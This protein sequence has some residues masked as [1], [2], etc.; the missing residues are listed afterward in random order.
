MSLITQADLETR[1]GAAEVTR[2][3]HGDGSQITSAIAQA[4]SKARSAALNIFTAASWDAMTSATLPGEALYHIVSDAVDILSAGSGRPNEIQAKA[5]EA[6]LWRSWLA[7]GT[8]N[9]F[10]S[11]LTKTESSTGGARARVGAP[12]CLLSDEFRC[13][14]RRI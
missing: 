8:V 7:A 12:S 14:V 9:A 10:D 6:K 11:V 3:S 5:D 4:E 13:K 1:V 2:Y